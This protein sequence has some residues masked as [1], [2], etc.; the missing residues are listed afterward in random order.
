MEILYALMVL[1]YFLG[2]LAVALTGIA[3]LW[4][5]VNVEKSLFGKLIG[6]CLIGIAVL[7]FWNLA[8]GIGVVLQ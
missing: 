2:V 7:E 8:R 1:L 4:V 6:M 5:S 3:V